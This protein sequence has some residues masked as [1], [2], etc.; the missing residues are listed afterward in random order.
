MEGVIAMLQTNLQTH[1]LPGQ[2]KPRAIHSATKDPLAPLG[3]RV[4]WELRKVL[5]RERHISM[6]VEEFH[7][8]IEEL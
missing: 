7:A 4:T 3:K 1:K 8:R 2:V 5:S 6:S